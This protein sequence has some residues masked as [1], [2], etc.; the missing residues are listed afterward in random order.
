MTN[1]QSHVVVVQQLGQK[2]HKSGGEENLPAAW[3]AA[4]RVEGENECEL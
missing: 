3:Q 1:H 2:K 4:V